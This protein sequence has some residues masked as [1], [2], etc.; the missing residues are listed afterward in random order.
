[1]SI[2]NDTD[3]LDRIG[4]VIAGIAGVAG[5]V[6]GGA[7]VGGGL[8]AAAC[9]GRAM[10][11]GRLEVKSAD[12]E[13]VIDEFIEEFKENWESWSNLSASATRKPEDL[14]SA[15]L[16]FEEYFKDGDP[17]ALPS[18]NLIIDQGRD[19]EKITQVL[20]ATAAERRPD[21]YKDNA[22]NRHNRSFFEGV[23]RSALARLLT[24]PAFAETLQPAFQQWVVQEIKGAREDI[25]NLCDKVDEK[26]QHWQSR[27]QYQRQL[28]ALGQELSA[29][30]AELR[31]T[32][33]RLEATESH[34]QAQQDKIIEAKVDLGIVQREKTALEDKL[35]DIER[36]Y[37]QSQR[38]LTEAL[39]KLPENRVEDVRS[40]ISQSPAGV[41]DE[42][43]EIADEMD[44]QSAAIKFEAANLYKDQIRYTEALV[45]YEKAVALDDQNAY[46]L[47]ALA[48]MHYEMGQYLAAEPLFEDALAIRKKQ[49]GDEHTD[50]A[51]SLNNLAGLYQSQG[52][53]EQAEPLLEDALAILRNQLGDEHFDVTTGLNNLGWQYQYQGRYEQAESLYEDALAIRRK[54]LGDEHP[55]VA[56]SLNNLAS[57]YQSQGRY[58]Q[59]EPL[60][61]DALAIRRKQLG[62]KH[63]D[64]AI[65][66]N[67][68]A[69]LHKIQG[70]YEQAEPLYLDALA[71]WKKQLG[72]EHPNV[73]ASLNNLAE[74]YKSQGRYEKAEP[75]YVDALAIWK[76][77]L[78]DEHPNVATS[79]N[80]L[81]QLYRYQGRDEKAEPLYK[82]ALVILKKKLGDEHPNTQLVKRNYTDL[83][84]KIVT[85]P[86]QKRTLDG[87]GRTGRAKRE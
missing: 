29:R 36:A 13:H 59:A 18:A 76:K 78:G 33:M 5:T 6:V 21:I 1:M 26:V 74:L 4:V 41:P 19:A 87:I 81:G 23:V 46:Y 60:F 10:L 83:Q 62:D 35:A 43:V 49:L 30:E 32:L 86:S 50:V 58:E 31:L 2:F 37:Q 39:S 25:K 3:C 28:H 57:L 42:L 72:D 55:D 54:Q 61:E 16:S 8:L 24:M 11:L 56:D 73:A 63:P 65:S 47:D 67:N 44:V 52:R 15:A 7:A 34:T 27:E 45:Q 75:L 84:A 64:V 51:T 48:T 22:F 79:L 80:N 71:I 69:G 70:R 82:N 68:L 17:Q 77:Q 66:L 12:A 40:K 53:Y 85:I 14:E 38:A 9:A 20:L